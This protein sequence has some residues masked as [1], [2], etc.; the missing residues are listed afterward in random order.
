MGRQTFQRR[1]MLAQPCPQYACPTQDSRSPPWRMWLRPSMGFLRSSWPL[2][3]LQ[4]HESSELL[5]TFV[6]D[7]SGR[8]TSPEG[9]EPHTSQ[10]CLSPTVPVTTITRHLL[11]GICFQGALQVLILVIDRKTLYPTGICY[12]PPCA[13]PSGRQWSSR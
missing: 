3:P 12:C 10:A 5:A 1:C 11:P 9:S 7:V 13:R 8:T 6:L 2:R 4:V